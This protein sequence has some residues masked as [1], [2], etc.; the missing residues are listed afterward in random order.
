MSVTLIILLFLG[1]VL[2]VAVVNVVWA[3]EKRAPEPASGDA[4]RAVGTA[5]ETKPTAPVR[6]LAMSAGEPVLAHPSTPL[7][8][9]FS[10][11]LEAE[12]APITAAVQVSASA[13]GAGRF[14]YIQYTEITVLPRRG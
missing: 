6:T 11:T 3:A 8:T 12:R 1:G 2:L 7:H 14:T 10:E 4:T 9:Q 5:T 13:S